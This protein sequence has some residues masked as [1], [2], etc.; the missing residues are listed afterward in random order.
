MGINLSG[1]DKGVRQRG[2][3]AELNLVPFI[4]LLSVCITFLL[5]TAAWTQVEALQVDQGE[6]QHMIRAL[7]RIRAEG[8]ART[9]IA[10]AAL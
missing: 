1:P 5:L 9:A 2:M 10:G 7:D 4:D 6:Y 8:Y 3:S